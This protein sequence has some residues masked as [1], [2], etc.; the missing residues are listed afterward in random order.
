MGQVIQM[1]AFRKRRDADPSTLKLHFDS[2]FEVR[3]RISNLWQQAAELDMSV[4]SLPHVYQREQA[5]IRAMQL[6]E[7]AYKLAKDNGLVIERG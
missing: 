5:V 3:L 4:R 7:E 1:E 2:L 6:R